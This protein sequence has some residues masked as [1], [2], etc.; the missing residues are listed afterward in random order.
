MSLA[1][2]SLTDPNELQANSGPSGST[3]LWVAVVMA[4]LMSDCR[5]R[6]SRYRPMTARVIVP[7]T[8]HDI[9]PERMPNVDLVSG[10]PLAIA[11]RIL[12]FARLH[13][14]AARLKRMMASLDQKGVLAP[15]TGLLTQSALC[16]NVQLDSPRELG[17]G[18]LREL[19]LGGPLPSPGNVREAAEM[20]SG[21]RAAP[22]AH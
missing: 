10:D 17:L 2:S 20:Q 14:F 8:V 4:L 6:H 9:D 5:E 16:S 19:R 7:N 1:K 15:D 22:A 21:F 18:S 11:A 13:A 3:L 12:P